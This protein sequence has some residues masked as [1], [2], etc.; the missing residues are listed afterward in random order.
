VQCN[1]QAGILKDFDIHFT[2]TGLY[3]ESN[4]FKETVL[5]MNESEP[6]EEFANSYL[7]RAKN[8]VAYAKSF[9]EQLVLNEKAV[10]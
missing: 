8:F 10:V 2:Q 9:R 3:T 7:Q 1:T 4:N 5:Q 6:T